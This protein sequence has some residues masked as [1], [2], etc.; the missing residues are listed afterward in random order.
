MHTFE[1]KNWL[2]DTFRLV[3]MSEFVL[4]GNLLAMARGQ[5]MVGHDV[6]ILGGKCTSGLGVP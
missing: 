3:H 2:M 5:N 6:L 1:G 4:A